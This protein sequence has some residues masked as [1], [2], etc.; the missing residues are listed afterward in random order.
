MSA[1]ELPTMDAEAAR[2]VLVAFALAPDG[3]PAARREAIARAATAWRAAN[4]EAAADDEDGLAL[5]YASLHLRAFAGAGDPP[6]RP[7][8]TA[9]VALGHRLLALHTA[10]PRPW[11]LMRIDTV[12]P[13]VRTG[14]PK[15][16]LRPQ[17]AWGTLRVDGETLI[18][19]IPPAAWRH[20]VGGEPLLAWAIARAK[21][22]A[23]TFDKDAFIARLA[24][25]CRIAVDT[26]ALVRAAG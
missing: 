5:V 9:A 24:G 3:G 23:G 4:A 26:V 2:P 21:G 19:G 10:A 15:L 17:A 16:L 6:A 1:V 20:D 7:A 8:S 18:A 11:P 25:L 14:R 13:E 22:D 12:D